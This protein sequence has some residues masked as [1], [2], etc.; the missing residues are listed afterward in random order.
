MGRLVAEEI[1]AANVS[2]V[3]G[4][5]L[6]TDAPPQGA[7]IFPDIMAL[8]EAADVMIDFTHAS[9]VSLHAESLT[10][11]RCTWVLGTTGLSPSDQDAVARAACVIPI[12]QAA[13]FSPGVNIVLGLAEQLGRALPPDAYDADIVDMHHRQKIDAPSGTALAMGQAVATGRGVSLADI[14]LPARDGHT[15]ARPTGGIGFAAL[16]GGQIVG[17]HSLILTAGDEQ[18]ILTHRA[19]DRRAFARGAVRAALWSAGKP[20]GLY[21]MRDVLGMSQPETTR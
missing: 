21:G 20:P 17:E 12:V 5:C 1:L 4:T 13:N 16:R 7:T 19:F 14:R 18:I 3:G 8:A 6:H 11:T 10:V 15:G 2:L 9:T